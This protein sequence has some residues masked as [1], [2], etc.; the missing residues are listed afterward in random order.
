MLLLLPDTTRRKQ[1][2]GTS[3]K[4]SLREHLLPFRRIIGNGS[5]ARESLSR[6]DSSANSSNPDGIRA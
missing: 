4:D 2:N 5:A 6:D 1:G 3:G